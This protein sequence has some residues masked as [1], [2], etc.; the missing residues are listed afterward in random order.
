MK[1]ITTSPIIS[2]N[3]NKIVRFLPF[4]V[5][6]RY[7]FHAV[8]LIWP[9][10]QAWWQD[11]SVLTEVAGTEQTCTELA[12]TVRSAL[13]T[14]I[15]GNIST[16]GQ[17]HMWSFESWCATPCP[18]LLHEWTCSRWWNQGPSMKVKQSGKPP[19]TYKECVVLKGSNCS[20]YAYETLQLLFIVT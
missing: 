1:V 19:T 18:S 6:Q 8:S 17:V 12:M 5:T 3:H 16:G 2:V 7:L 11:N 13:A 14:D 4:N 9:W 10:W 20:L 15:H